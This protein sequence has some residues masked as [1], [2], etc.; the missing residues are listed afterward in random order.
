MNIENYAKKIENKRY[1]TYKSIC[2][3][4]LRG[5]NCVIAKEST[6]DLLGYS[7]GGYREKITGF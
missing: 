2:D 5:L 3:T 4:L 7:N 1:L 6:T